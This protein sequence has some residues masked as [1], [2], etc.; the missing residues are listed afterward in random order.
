MSL[1][2]PEIE[3]VEGVRRAYETAVAQFAAAAVS[4]N[5]TDAERWAAITFGL[6]EALEEPGRNRADA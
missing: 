4:G 2:R 1:S 3:V 5:L 6:V